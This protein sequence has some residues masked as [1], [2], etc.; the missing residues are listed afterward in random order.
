[1]NEQTEELIPSELELRAAQRRLESSAPDWRRQKKEQN[2]DKKEGPYERVRFL[3]TL[4][5]H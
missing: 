2:F 4:L 3:K 1:M 5:G